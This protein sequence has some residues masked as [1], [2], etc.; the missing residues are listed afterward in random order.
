MDLHLIYVRTAKE[1]DLKLSELLSIESLRVSLLLT[2]I[3]LNLPKSQF[4]VLSDN[5]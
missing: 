2:I 1:R 4:Q 3:I 5:Y